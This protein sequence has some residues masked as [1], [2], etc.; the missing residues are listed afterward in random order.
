MQKL[1]KRQSCRIKEIR[2]FHSKIRDLG[3]DCDNLF[4]TYGRFSSDIVSFANKYDM[5]LWNGD[6][7]SKIYLSMLI[8]RFGTLESSDY[9]EI[10]I[11]NAFSVSMI[12]EEI[13]RLDL[14]NESRKNK[15]ISYFQ[16]ILYLWIPLDSMRMDKRGKSHLIHDEDY[17][18]LDAILE[19][20]TLWEWERRCIKLSSNTIFSPLFY[21]V[22]TA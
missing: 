9:N 15:R 4:V 10:R 8:G 20:N 7:L 22:L 2:D 21:W 11:E 1:W 19:Q 12:F 6:K 18:V 13:A 17:F 3:H 16:T 5:E 14:E